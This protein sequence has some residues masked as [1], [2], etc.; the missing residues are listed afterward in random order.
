MRRQRR[1]SF[2]QGDA[3]LH[4]LLHLLEGRHAYLPHALA[5][6]AELVGE[7]LERDRFFGEPARLEDAPLP[8]VEPG[9]C[10]GEGLA[11]AAELLACGECR[12][13]V[14][15]LV[16]QPVLPLAGSAVLAD[17]SVERYIA[18][19]A[20]FAAF[21]AVQIWLAATIL[22]RLSEGRYIRAALWSCVLAFW[23][24]STPTGVSPAGFHL[25]A[26]TATAG[27][28]FERDKRHDEGI[29]TMQAP[30]V[31]TGLTALWDW[32]RRTPVVG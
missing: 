11:A 29:A 31:N 9:E 26:A 28:C 15:I 10:R 14:G 17:R 22:L 4:R 6:D 25:C 24:T 18:P 27:V 23:S 5:R 7:L 19:K 3:V 12:L 1:R 16:D 21:I 32:A 20:F 30:V 2:H 13:L 8:V